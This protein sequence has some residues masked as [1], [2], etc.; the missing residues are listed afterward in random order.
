VSPVR[1]HATDSLRAEEFSDMGKRKQ[2]FSVIVERDESGWYV[3]E[4]PAL[5][6]CYTQGKTY[7]AAVENIKDVIALCLTELKAQGKSI[8]ASPQII[9]IQPV[10]VLV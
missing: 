8:P 9:G 3:V 10:E 4:C 6:A 5:Q 2:V 1:P 7:D